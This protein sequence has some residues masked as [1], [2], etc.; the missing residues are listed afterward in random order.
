M[1][2]SD[3]PCIQESS[4][5]AEFAS[6]EVS[7]NTC[8]PCNHKGTQRQATQYCI[9]CKELLCKG[10]KE[11]HQS[12]KQSRD[13]KFSP[14]AA[15]RRIIIDSKV[16]SS[17]KHDIRMSSDKRFPQVTSCVFLPGG[18]IL[19]CDQTNMKIKLLDNSY[20]ITD[21]LEFPS[22]T[23]DVAVVDK[24]TLIVALVD[25]KSLQYVDMETKMKPGR[26]ILL[27]KM[28]LALEYLE[29]EIY[30]ACKVPRKKGTGEVLIVDREGIVNRRVGIK[31]NGSCMFHAP[32]HFT[33]SRA[34]KNIFVSDRDTSTVTGLSPSGNV[35]YQYQSHDLDRPRGV[36][37]DAV[38]NL[39]VCGEYSANVLILTAT[40]EIYG[41]LLTGKDIGKQPCSIAYRE[42]DSTLLIGS[43]D[44]N[45]ILAFEL[46]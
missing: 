40:G 43:Y 14:V 45:Y 5:A 6:E 8:S 38:D 9:D 25:H 46:Q 24:N 7:I 30:V 31:A 13:H 21:S 44:C 41:T 32:C 1:A 20:K 18:K 15:D 10:C 22:E 27:P 19:V 42:N 4:D 12:F 37:V 2:S 28:P 17:S 26:I 11:S 16:V 29:D 33:V 39:L 3:H 35:L 23:R 34:T 36:Y